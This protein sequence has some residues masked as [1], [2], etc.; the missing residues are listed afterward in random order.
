MTPPLEPTGEAMGSVRRR[1]FDALDVDRTL[2]S[3]FWLKSEPKLFANGR[4]EVC[5]FSQP[6]FP[7]GHG[8]VW[9][10]KRRPH[11][12]EIVPSV[13]IRPIDDHEALALTQRAGELRQR[14]CLSA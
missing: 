1:T 3:V 7:A 11:E 8:R 2:V 4:K 9:S 14:H 10:P 5:S 12:I 13:E 6:R